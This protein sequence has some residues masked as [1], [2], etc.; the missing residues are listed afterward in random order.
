LFNTISTGA[1]P[2]FFALNPY[3]E[4]GITTG[5]MWVSCYSSQI[6]EQ[7]SST[8][9][10]LASYAVTGH[11]QPLGLS[12]ENRAPYAVSGVTHNGTVFSINTANHTV[13]YTGPVGSNNYGF[14]YAPVSNS[15]WGTDI[16][17]GLIFEY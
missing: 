10:L 7:F 4:T 12:I 5:D 8:G 14:A 2:Q 3:V 1:E 9:G 11:G 16:N 17:Q 15:F 13:L 6:V